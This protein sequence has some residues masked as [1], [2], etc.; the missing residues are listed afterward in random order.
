M[1][2]TGSKNKEQK[3]ESKNAA[4]AAAS[5][6]S[7]QLQPKS[8]DAAALP[9]RGDAAPAANNVASQQANLT[10]SN[11]SVEAPAGRANPQDVS[12]TAAPGKVPRTNSDAA[13]TNPDVDEDGNP[14][15][16]PKGDWVKTEGT[17]YY[18]SATENLYYHPPSCQFYDPTNE[19]WYDPEKDEWY[20]DDA[21]D[22][23]AA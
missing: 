14:V 9:K 3:P 5:G 20:H 12:S 1:G 7:Q 10:P 11:K 8:G 18:Y 15:V 22:A 16:L 21:S 6:G 4:D 13:V 17:P 23:E 19:M 2:C